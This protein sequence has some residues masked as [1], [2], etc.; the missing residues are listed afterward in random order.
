M[1]KR[2]ILVLAATFVAVGLCGCKAVTEKNEQAD[3]LAKTVLNL[4]ADNKAS[5]I[6]DQYGCAELNRDVTPET[7][8]GVIQKLSSVGKP[9]SI[10]RTAF[11][12]K[13]ENDL[14]TGEYT[15]K[16]DWESKSG[17]FIL[18]TKWEDG[19]CR[20]LGIKFDAK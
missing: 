20:I 7:W 5:E 9:K 13:T 17:N 4:A 15:Y 14:T 8:A 6:Y 10:T 1:M 18:K 3:A 16:V 19:Q 11:E 2:T 12:V